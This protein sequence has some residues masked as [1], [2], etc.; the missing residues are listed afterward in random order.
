MIYVSKIELEEI[1][2]LDECEILEFLRVAKEFQTFFPW[3]ESGGP[4]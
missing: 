3:A 4:W 1:A 2:R